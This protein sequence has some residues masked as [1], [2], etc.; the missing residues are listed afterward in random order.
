MPCSI[1]RL[2]QAVSA[3]TAIFV[4]L[5]G[6]GPSDIIN[7][8]VLLE[9]PHCSCP[10]DTWIGRRAHLQS[11]SQISARSYDKPRFNQQSPGRYRLEAAYTSCG[12][13]HSVSGREEH[14]LA[15]PGNVSS[16]PLGCAYQGRPVWLIER[17]N[18]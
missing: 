18:G 16:S 3:P 17:T 7:R 5:T 10:R 4:Y 1:S 11:L 8:K 15:Q 6:H 12:S 9:V 2:L 13:L 14:H